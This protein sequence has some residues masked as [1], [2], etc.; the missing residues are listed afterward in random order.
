MN[1]NDDCCLKSIYDLEDQIM[2]CWAT[3]EDISLIRKN[4]EHLLKEGVL[5]ESL[6]GLEIMVDLRFEQLFKVFEEIVH[7]Q[8]LV[9]RS[10]EIFS[11]DFDQDLENQADEFFEMPEAQKITPEELDRIRKCFVEDDYPPESLRPNQLNTVW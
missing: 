6:L 3:K 4:T 8:T 11:P 9:K 2:R 7:T 1:E 10:T 5:E